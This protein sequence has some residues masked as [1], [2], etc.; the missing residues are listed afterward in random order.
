M[1]IKKKKRR[2]K[3]TNQR[4]SPELKK[5]DIDAIAK[6]IKIEHERALNDAS[7]EHGKKSRNAIDLKMGSDSRR[8]VIFK[9]IIRDLR[10]IYLKNFLELT[11][12]HH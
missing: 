11:R 2:G 9:S 6:A 1:Q 3:I 7:L 12:Y 10:K 5:F 8:D 4:I